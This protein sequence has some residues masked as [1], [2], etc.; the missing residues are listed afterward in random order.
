[1]FTNFN[2]KFRKNLI[3]NMLKLIVKNFKNRD[4]NQQ[5]Y[6]LQ[7]YCHFQILFL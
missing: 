4:I 5:L 1:M 6:F 2:K 3:K 7:I